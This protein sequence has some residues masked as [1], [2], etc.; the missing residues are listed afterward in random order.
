MNGRMAP[1]IAMKKLLAQLIQRGITDKNIL[2]AI[3]GIP[4]HLFVDDALA[5]RAYDDITLPI[6]NAQ[7]ISQPSI[8][9]LM[10]GLLEVKDGLKVL[11]IGT[12]SGYQSA[13]L[14][15]FT[16]RLF[17][18]ER[19][20]ALLEK[21]KKRHADLKIA[22]ISYRL[23]DGTLGWP[24]QGLFDRI[25]VTAGAPSLP[26]P[27]FEQLAPEGKLLIPTGSKEEQQLTVYTKRA[28]GTMSFKKLGK[29]S[30][31][32]LV[33]QYGWKPDEK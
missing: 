21:A 10:T 31:V 17:T 24:G 16:R 22:N 25:I 23:G 33:G 18:V 6:G 12:G 9:A 7:T 28:D 4:R 30:F 13:I 29:V 26:G 19:F 15:R 1:D 20:S 3:A 27:L 11:E 14:S 8:V 32:P 5:V 2:E